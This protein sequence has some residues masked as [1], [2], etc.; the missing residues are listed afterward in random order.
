M[1][2]PAD[3]IAG[4]L[5]GAS[6]KDRQLIRE[7]YD[8]AEQAHGTE[9]R[10]SGDLYMTHPR[11]IALTLAKLG[12][13]KETVIAGILHDTI[14]DTPIQV[15]EIEK[16]FG[17]TVRFLV[18]G[19]TKL[20]KLKY[21]GVER[22]VE[23]LRRLLVA[24]ANDIRVIIIKLADRLHNMQTIQY[25][26]P[27]EKRQRIAM[28]TMEVYVPIAERLGIGV[29][30]AQLEDLSFKALEPERYRDVAVFL[31]EKEESSKDALESTV[32]DIRK[33][34]A[35]NGVRKFHTETRIKSVHSFAKKL[36]RK[37]NDI[38]KIHDIFAVRI[39]VPSI[40]DCYRALGVVHS[41]W[42]PMIGRVKDYI[43]L[44]KANG[45]RTLH[46]TVITPHGIT[47]E[48]Q[49]RS[50]EMQRESKFGIASHLVYK[51]PKE[52][53]NTAG[54]A[55]QFVPSLMKVARGHKPDVQNAPQW[56]KELT[57]AAEEF[58]E[59]NAFHEA[60]KQDFFAERMFI[61]T[62]KGDVID[63][64]VGATTVDFAYTIHSDI[65]D[66]MMG[67]K[68]NGKMT[69]LETRL[70]NGDMVE[71]LTKKTAKPN[72]KWLEYAKTSTAKHH[73]R[74]ALNREIK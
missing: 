33:S 1:T 69:A 55:W 66:R 61:Y 49:I 64:P 63:L 13:D 9:T 56:L 27:E 37:G 29:L 60:L 44:P 57:S 59:Q 5:S 7:A 36:A 72:K 4:A 26:E 67:A 47:V 30:K 42:R 12:M 25:V 17:A 73:I 45:Y 46:T 50:E 20:S 15:D 39:I 23:S 70:K 40:E 35:E 3:E 41:L 16:R 34:L 53:M 8:F 24:T 28:E 52:R 2:H 38:D 71:I 32:R 22:H 43:A 62:P 54:W 19:V 68:V 74:N 21:R 11:A 58:Q 65:G 51:N 31:Q 6:A 18:E 48:I 10:K 14:E